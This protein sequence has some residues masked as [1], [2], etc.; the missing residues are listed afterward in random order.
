MLLSFRLGWLIDGHMM[1]RKNS[2][3]YLC[4]VYPF[5]TYVPT[6]SFIKTSYRFENLFCILTFL[7]KE[8]LKSNQ[9]YMPSL[10]LTRHTCQV[11]IIIL[12]I[13]IIIVI[14][15]ITI[16]MMIT[17]IM[18]ITTTIVI[19]LIIIIIM[20]SII[21]IYLNL[22]VILI[23]QSTCRYTCHHHHLSP[24]TPEPYPFPQAPD[25]TQW[26]HNSFGW[27]CGKAWRYSLLKG[28]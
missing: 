16:T 7:C 20:I 1:I 3:I 26:Y 25:T 2:F 27:R 15:I 6:F 8:I 21:K 18:I 17:I 9:M 13:I 10:L 14:I 19:I 11:L 22:Q 28:T 24:F 23:Y 4:R 12:I 5:E